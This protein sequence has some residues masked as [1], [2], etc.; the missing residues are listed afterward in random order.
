MRDLQLGILHT[1]VRI[2]T[3]ARRRYRIRRN[4]LILV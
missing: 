3:A 4:R 2:E 1:D